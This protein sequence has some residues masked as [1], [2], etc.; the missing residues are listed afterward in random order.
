MPRARSRKPI[1]GPPERVDPRP[2]AEIEAEVLERLNRRN[3]NPLGWTPA[4]RDPADG[5]AI[6]RRSGKGPVIADRQTIKI[7]YIK[8][9]NR[10]LIYVDVLR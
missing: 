8:I 3:A 6:L 2:I 4:G 10:G 7:S 5:M 9:T 1:E